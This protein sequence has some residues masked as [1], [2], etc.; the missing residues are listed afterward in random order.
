[1]FDAVAKQRSAALHSNCPVRP[2]A[3]AR[4]PKPTEQR[5]IGDPAGLSYF[6]ARRSIGSKRHPELLALAKHASSRFPK[7]VL[8]ELF[9]AVSVPGATSNH[10]KDA[11]RFIDSAFFTSADRAHQLDMLRSYACLKSS[12]RLRKAVTELFEVPSLGQ[13][14]PRLR[15]LLLRFASGP[16]PN[17]H[18]HP[19]HTVRLQA[20]W[21]ER[22]RGLRKGLADAMPQEEGEL[23]DW[24]TDLLHTV[25]RPFH[26]LRTVSDLDLLALVFGSPDAPKSLSYARFYAYGRDGHAEATIVSPDPRVAS[27]WKGST[28]LVDQ[29][30]EVRSTKLS[31]LEELELLRWIENNH[32]I[33]PD[34]TFRASSVPLAEFGHAR[35]MGDAVEPIANMIAS[36]RGPLSFNR[37]LT[38]RGRPAQQQ[39]HRL[40]AALA[41][42]A[43]AG[44]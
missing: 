15:R 3:P 33:G 16:K 35:R 28:P 36:G 24:I 32:A 13:S 25:D 1:M 43:T 18:S 7:Q 27:G 31:R 6:T 12:D 42:A 20:A 23:D 38:R 11:R 44:A 5:P 30:F 9:G 41:Q 39:R 10:L 40:R 17:A 2:R 26:I 37:T 4:P 22:V 14:S 34:E 21:A 29:L 8:R 19:S